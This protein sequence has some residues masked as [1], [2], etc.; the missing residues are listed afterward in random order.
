MASFMKALIIL[1]GVVALLALPFASAQ[2]DI[3]TDAASGARYRIERY[4]S[5]NFP[6]GMAFAPDGRLFYNEK[7]TGNVRV[8]SAD[9]RLQAQSVIHLPTDALQERGMLGIALDPNYSDNGYIWIGHTARGTSRDFPANRLVRFREVDGQGYDPEVMFSVPITTGQLLHNG[10]NVHFDAEGR[11]YFSLGDFGDAAYAQDINAPQGKI[12][13]FIVTDEGLAPSPDN[14][15]GAE[16]SV[17]ALGFRNP[18]DFAFD[19]LT[20]NLFVTENGPDCDDEINLVL[21]GFNYGWREDY[22]CVGKN[23]V[24]GLRLYGP[25]LLS[26]TPTI[27]PSGILFYDGAAFPQWRGD[28]FFCDWNFGELHRITLNESRTQVVAERILNLGEA[29]CRIDIVQGPEGGLYFG[30]VNEGDGAIYR[31]LPAD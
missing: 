4:V 15:F 25:P 9:G 20:A 2:G 28:L 3:F 11:L 21:P 18:F 8:V 12:H 13:R 24:S 10:G 29:T 27:A 30:T 23:L 1:F 17:Y 22:V 14:P 19:P 6:V 26:Y 5:A 16:N 7:T 31:L